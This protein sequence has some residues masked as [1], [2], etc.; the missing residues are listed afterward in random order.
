MRFFA[1]GP[2]IPDELLEARDRGNVVFL[3]GAGV[4]IPAGMPNF[5]GLAK[6]V[7]D[8]LGVSQDAHLRRLLSY[9]E[10]ERFPE[11]ARPPLDQIFNLLQQEYPASEI[12]YLIARRLRTK[13]RTCV[14][15]HRT[16]LRLSRS[17][18][19]KPQIVTTNFDLLFQY[20]DDSLTHY[21]PPTLPDLANGQDLNGLVYLHGRLNRNVRRGEARQGF[22]LSSSDF[23]RAYLAEGWATRFMRDL[24]DRYIVVLLGY[25]AND[26]PVEYLLQGLQASERRRREPIYAFVSLSNEDVQAAW[27]N[28]GVITLTYPLANRDH[29]ALWNTLEAWAERADDPL[30]WRQGI[31]E[32][33]RRGP[34][35]LEKHER[36]QVASLVRTVDGAKLFADADPPPPGEWLCVFDKY[37]RY[38]RVERDPYEELPKYDPLVEYGLDDDPPRPPGDQSEAIPLGDDFLSLRSTDSH[39][40]D[41]L[42]LAGMP[43]PDRNPLPARLFRLAL[44]IVKIAHEP[45]VPWWAA[46][47]SS[48]HP[49]LL[50][51][52]EQRIR[53]NGA[54]F[55]LKA[56]SIWD[57]LI[58]RFRTARDD[59]FDGSL[60]DVNQRTKD[61]GWT[62]GV[63]REFERRISPYFKVV[64]R[65]GRSCGQPPEMDWSKLQVSDI[66]E[67]E[68]GFPHI[69]DITSEIPDEIL[70]E[71]Y[72]IG[73]RQLE[74]AIGMLGDI[75]PSAQETMKFYL[76][77]DAGAMHGDNPKVYLQWFRDLL[78]RM[79]ET[80][81]ELVRADTVF[82]PREDLYFFNMLRLYAWS[83]ENL[84]TGDE[85]GAEL[86][87]LSDKTFWD[88]SH[89]RELLHLL[90]RRWQDISTDRRKLIEERIVDGRERFNGESDDS[91]NRWSPIQSAG[92]LGWLAMQGCDL[93]NETKAILPRLRNAHPDWTPEWDED[94]DDDGI[95]EG[96]WVTTDS[97][98]SA[99]LNVQLAQVVPLAREHTT[100]SF[101]ELTDYKPFEGLVKQRPSGLSPP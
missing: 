92:I 47:H 49:F 23:G 25:S 81:P 19:G 90:R 87:S 5:L 28:R 16:I 95:S 89:R 4:S 98:A 20:A 84:F 78:N 50:I 82:W 33:A 30:A 71:V 51:R 41:H 2:S 86:L 58:E 18:D 64:S 44:W 66:A 96:G 35:N 27:S 59:E 17:A 38:G 22:I 73:R 36:G 93:S 74:L 14:S 79:V 55:P 24:L 48:L 54:D 56:R 68:I 11:A 101:S 29:S 9:W 63:L 100:S 1:D 15:T 21:V 13:P 8:E 60:Y 76:S 37:V 43:H 46:K 75:G 83:F 62:S 40:S 6:S 70:P 10:D 34:R 72:G 45:I 94:A 53:Q 39:K 91:Y 67:F 57:L 88:N 97:D 85:V 65:F 61:E 31:V 42:R 99:I 12:D 52:I 80:R 69:L 26:P 77:N 32:L 7:A 3:C